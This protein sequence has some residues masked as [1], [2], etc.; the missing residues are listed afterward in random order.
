M[1]M[2]CMGWVIVGVR[3]ESV[4]WALVVVSVMVNGMVLGVFS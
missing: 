3:S 4:S 1:K 2:M